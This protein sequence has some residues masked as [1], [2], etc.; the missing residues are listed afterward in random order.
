MLK[1]KRLDE[2]AEQTSLFELIENAF[3]LKEAAYNQSM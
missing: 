2:S 1:G 3:I